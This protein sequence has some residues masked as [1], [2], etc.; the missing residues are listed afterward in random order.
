[1][2]RGQTIEL[3]F[4]QEDFA[5]ML[6]ISVIHVNRT[7][8]KLAEEKIALYRKGSIEVRD[9]ARLKQIAAFDPDYLH[10]G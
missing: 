9:S 10:L 8:R 3:P 1:M 2:M 5:D 6:G 4:N 7:F